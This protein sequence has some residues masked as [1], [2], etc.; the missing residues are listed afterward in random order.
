MK[1]IYGKL[2]YLVSKK[3]TLDEICNILSMNESEV[4][5][6]L[7]S[8][9]IYSYPKYRLN[10]GNNTYFLSPRKEHLK[11]ILL[12]DTHMCH[13]NDNI[14]LINKIYDDAEDNNVDYIFHSGDVCDGIINAKNY[15][16]ELKC[17]RYNTQLEYMIDK[18]P[19]YSGKTYMISGNHDDKWYILT[20]KDILSDLE[21]KRDDIVYLGMNRGFIR[22]NNINF[23]IIHGSLNPNTLR[24]FKINDYINTSNANIIHCGHMHTSSYVNE[25]NK[26]FFR[27]A[28]LC[29]ETKLSLN[30]NLKNE[31]SIYYI[32]LYQ[33][34]NGIKKLNKKLE[35]FK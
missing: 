16:K 13:I 22:L 2:K 32:D 35:V 24:Q 18:Y 27:T 23:E 14:D 31:N 19:R 29:G 33:D 30:H 12:G 17:D 15:N 9:G 21:S 26:Y 10:I 11:I 25:K 3:K 4:L 20:G 1:E 5:F 28:S 6:L 8:V 34:E 7:N